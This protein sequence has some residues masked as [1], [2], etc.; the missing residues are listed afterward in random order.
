MSATGISLR[1]P[2]EQYVSYNGQNFPIASYNL[3]EKST[4]PVPSQTPLPKNPGPYSVLGKPTITADF[5]NKVL[6]SYHSPTAGMGQ[7]LYNLGVKYG[8]DPVYA[9]ADLTVQSRET[10]HDSIVSEIITALAAHLKVAPA[11]EQKDGA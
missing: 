5:I 8:I 9:L 3:W 11:A 7:D 6:A 1:S 10:P 4:G 2:G